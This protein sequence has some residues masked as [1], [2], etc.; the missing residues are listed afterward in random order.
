MNQSDFANLLGLTQS[1]LSKYENGLADAA[2]VAQVL[3][4]KLSINPT[5]YLTG[6]GT[7]YIESNDRPMIAG[8]SITPYIVVSVQKSTGFAERLKTARKALGY[9]QEEAA[10]LCGIARMTFSRYEKGE[11]TPGIIFQKS[12]AASL[13]VDPEWLMTGEGI[14]PRGNGIMAP[15][16][17]YQFTQL[18]MLTYAA[19]ATFDALKFFEN[20]SEYM[21]SGYTVLK[22]PGYD[23]KNAVVI[24]IEG[25]SMEPK[26]PSGSKIVAVPMPENQW[27]YAS[28]YIAISLK[29][30]VFM[31]KRVKSA[32]PKSIVLISENP[33][34]PEEREVALDS[35][36]IMWKV[37][38]L[39]YA[40]I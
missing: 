18:P 17:N 35:I 27:E 29:A 25:N 9:N 24:N 38:H 15:V 12:I 2:N 16:S 20:D 39:V 11:T 19:A 6:Q 4:E 8:E 37:L 22:Q 40:P 14:P 26:F 13:N 32:G 31:F 7:M 1:S 30:E 33:Q 21:G 23:Y 36:N 5:W 34:F 3:A 28:G 10:K